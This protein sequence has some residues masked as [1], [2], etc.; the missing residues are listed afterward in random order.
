MFSRTRT[1]AL[2]ED[3]DPAPTPR[4][5]RA[6]LAEK[7]ALLGNSREL[8]RAYKE[9]FAF[10]WRSLRRLGLPLDALDDAA[11]DVFIVALRRRSEFRG[12]SSYR[13]WLFGIAANVAREER[14]KGRRAEILEPIDDALQS[15][16]ASP[17]ERATDAEAVRFVEAF[18]STLDDA[19][20]EVFILAELEQSA[21]PASPAS[22]VASLSAQD[23]QLEIAG[24]QRAQQL[25]HAGSAAQAVTALDQLARQVPVGALMEERDAT[26]VIALCT[27]GRAQAAGV[28]A[29]LARYPNSVHSGRV[30]SACSRAS[31]Q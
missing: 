11:Q 6:A 29:F 7:L 30:R 19:K 1:A 2:R 26:R 21:S 9:H 18:L 15:P 24:L 31:F 8:D 14:R 17:L 13:T 12:R 23:M 25:L 22:P 3:A 20:R 4:P 16:Q 5:E 27:L 10:V 28:D